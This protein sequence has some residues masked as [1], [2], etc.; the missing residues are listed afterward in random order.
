LLLQGKI[1]PRT[2]SQMCIHYIHGIHPHITK[3]KQNNAV[4]DFDTIFMIIKYHMI[5]IELA[6]HKIKS[7]NYYPFNVHVHS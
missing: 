2:A 7:T 6:V 3:D 5:L 4:D 1:S